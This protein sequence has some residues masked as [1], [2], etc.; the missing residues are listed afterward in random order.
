MTFVVHLIL[1]PL[2]LSNLVTMPH[3]PLWILPLTIPMLYLLKSNP[4][5]SRETVIP[6]DE[7]RVLLLGA[8]SGVGKD[9]AL[10]YARR[11]AKVF[12]LARRAEALEEVRR[13]CEEAAAKAGKK[14][15]VLVFP[16]DLTKVA[17]LV[18][19]REMIVKGK[20]VS[21]SS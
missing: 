14:A 9:L 17:D 18:S 4:L 15:E 6:P 19:A 1:S 5:P 16:G 3:L 20:H 13:E 10:A 7:E 12:L 11:G 2:N 8:S 21:D